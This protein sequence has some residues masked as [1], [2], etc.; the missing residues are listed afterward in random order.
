MKKSLVL[1]ILGLTA[2][3]V[4]SYGQGAMFLDNYLASTFNPIA[5]QGGGLAGAGFTVQ[6]YY[7][8]T[9]NV[10][11]VG[12]VATDPTGIA[13][14]T[15]LGGGLVAAT[16]LGSTATLPANGLASLNGYFYS[17]QTFAIQASGT[18][19]SFTL[20]VVAYNGSS[21]DTSTMRGHSAAVYGLSVAPQFAG[22]GGADIGTF[23]PEGTSL[24]NLPMFS[25]KP[26]PEPTTLA[27]GG[28]GGLALLLLRRK[29]S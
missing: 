26:V 23:F 2:A 11:T 28:L 21:Y 27:L 3:A 29:Q 13:D 8:P 14:P 7:N 22:S 19:G 4:S 17:G 6:L 25:V 16:G 15:T 5:V 9:V 1:G 24:A 10:N 18:P 12:S 20:M